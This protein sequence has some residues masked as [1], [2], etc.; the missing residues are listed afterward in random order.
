MSDVFAHRGF[1]GIYPENT[2]L[3]FEK[4]IETGCKGIELDVQLTRDGVPVILHD[5]TLDRTTDATGF[6]KDFTLDEIKQMPIRHMILG[7][8]SKQF[9]PTLREYFALVCKTNLV[10]N[11]EFKTSVF[12]YPGIEES[13]ISLVREFKLDDSVQY[14]SFNHFSLERCRRIEPNAYCGV[15][16]YAWLID[17]GAYAKRLNGTSINAC[18]EYLSKAVVQEIHENG[19]IA[20][21]YTPNEPALMHW[22]CQNGVDVLITNEPEMAIKICREYE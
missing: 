10:T 12:E 22:L 7:D 17:A 11:I 1:S 3:A 20:Q 6:V 15:L 8:A 16:I 4:A 19:I 18:S 13:V 9:V 14:S 5:E 2:L 21:A